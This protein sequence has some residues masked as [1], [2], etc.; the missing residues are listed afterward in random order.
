MEPKQSVFEVKEVVQVFEVFS[1][2]LLLFRCTRSSSTVSI[3]GEMGNVEWMAETMQL[4]D[5]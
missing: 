3:T 5:A 2:M 4:T 1:Y